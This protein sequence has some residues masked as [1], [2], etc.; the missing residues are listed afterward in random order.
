MLLNWNTIDACFLFSRFHIHS[1][2]EFFLTCLGAFFLVLLLEFIRRLQRKFD[3]HLRA[4]NAILQERERVVPDEMEEKLLG[5][6]ND[7]K[8]RELFKQRTI[9]VVIEQAVRG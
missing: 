8:T 4:K 1:S 7:G 2:F 6:G 3:A 5:N 9:V